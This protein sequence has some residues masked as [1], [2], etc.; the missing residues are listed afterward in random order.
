MAL[1]HVAHREARHGKQGLRL[2][3]QALAVLHGTGGMIGDGE[4]FGVRLPRGTEFQ[5][6]RKF[7]D[8]TGEFR[9]DL[10]LVR[11]DRIFAQHEAVILDGGA[12]TRRGDEDG[13]ETFPLNLRPP[14]VDIAPR[15]L[16]RVFLAA[17]VVNQHAAAALALRQNH[18][19]A[20]PVDEPDRG[21]VDGWCQHRWRTA[22]QKRNASVPV[23]VAVPGGRDGEDR[24]AL[25]GTTRRSRRRG[26]GQECCEASPGGAEALF[27]TGGQR[28]YPEGGGE[29]CPHA[30]GYGSAKASMRRNNR[31]ESGRRW[32]FSI[33]VRA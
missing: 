12:T 19:H 13:I 27:T 29:A 2:L 7:G 14:S 23:M 26:K 20:R 1:R 21:L 11:I 6:E 16:E 5:R 18:L 33:Q 24:R 31:S 15:G 3:A 28:L 30:A 4:R 9:D 22:R 32:I 10:G 17:H 8:I 25:H